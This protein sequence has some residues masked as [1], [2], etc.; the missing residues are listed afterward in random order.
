M[1]Y[2][3]IVVGGGPGGL[4]AAKTAAED[5]LKVILVERKK[6]ITEINRSCVQ[7]FY[8][9]K[10][11]PNKKGLHADG[12]IEPVSVEVTDK[13]YRFHFPGPGFSIDYNG[14]LKPLYNWIEVS[15]SKYLIYPRKHNIW[16]YVFDKEALLSELL[17]SAQ[18]A[19]AEILP[20]TIGM[21]AEN[22]PDGVKVLVRGK[23]RQQTLEARSAIA[24]D[25]LN[26]AIVDSLGLNKKRRVLGPALK[27]VGYEL[28]GVETDL[29][30]FSWTSISIPS[31]SPLPTVVTIMMGELADD[32]HV[33][34]SV[35]EED[36]QKFMKHPNF[37][38][39][40]RNARVVKK[41]AVVIGA[42]YGVLTAIREP[43]EGN[44]VIVGDAGAITETW[45]QGA[46]AS[47]YMAVKAIEKEF[48]GQKGYPKYIDWWQKAF[49]MH[50]PDY[51][52]MVYEAF[53]ISTAWTCDEDVD[54]VYKRFQDKEA[55]PHMI[56]VENLELIKEGR[57]ALYERLKKGFEEA[58]KMMPKGGS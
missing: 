12:Y 26:S 19:G 50:T 51:L 55:M 34:V 35:L 49:Y 42:K 3:L 30:P 15:P 27:L 20:E 48:D 43:V 1:K 2:D 31:L 37:A 10:L 32:K 33:I 47:A 6:N 21:G 23:A 7:I 41:T 56:I 11:S 16:G 29:S 13:T 22:T 4:M 5:G 28:E 38:S 25:G 24:A 14:P 40:F 46:V 39:W 53:A 57:P 54:Y 17:A 9:R 52:Q 44:M 45:V 58:E 18:R 36:I 8:I